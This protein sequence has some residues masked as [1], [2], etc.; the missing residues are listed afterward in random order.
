VRFPVVDGSDRIV[1]IAGIDI[2]ITAQKRSE[3]E[4]AELLRRVEMARDA[5]TEA[6][7]AKTRFLASMSHE[8]RTPLNAIIG[9]TRIVSRNAE[10][11]PER[12]VDNLSKILVSAQHL[13]AL[14]DEILDLSRVEAGEVII[15]MSDTDVGEVVREVADSLEPL[16]DRPRVRLAVVADPELPQVRTDRDKVRQILLNLLSNAIKYTDDGSIVVR[17]ASDDGRLR[18]AVTDTGVGIPSDELGRV[19]DEFHRAETA[20]ARRRSGTGLGLTISRRL[21]RTLGGDVT[22]ESQVGAGSTFTL[23]L[24][25]T[26]GRPT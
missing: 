1:A 26:D 11:L 8:L 25:L 5:A 12:Q 15:E 3:A 24:P 22:A 13:L 7:T 4:T 16:V 18:V 2:D 9:F 14:I 6:G 19:F 10:A 17:A 21:A 20:G 23:D